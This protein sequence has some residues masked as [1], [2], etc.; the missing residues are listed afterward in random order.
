VDVGRHQS[1]NNGRPPQRLELILHDGR[2]E[3]LRTKARNFCS[4]SLGVRQAEPSS[5]RGKSGRNVSRADAA[6]RARAKEGSDSR[7]TPERSSEWVSVAHGRTSAASESAGH[8][9]RGPGPRGFIEGDRAADRHQH[10]RRQVLPRHAGRVRRI[11]DEPAPR[12][13]A[14]GIAKA[15]AAGVYKGRPASIDATQVRAMKAQG[16]GRIRDREG[17]QDRPRVSLSGR[18]LVDR[19]DAAPG[20]IRS[21]CLSPVPANALVSATRPEWGGTR[22]WPIFRVSNLRRLRFAS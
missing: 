8:R 13:P 10:R 5:A 12:A 20:Q 22:A 9:P 3:R 2:T 4:N 14:Q 16:L 6:K 19:A 1:R 21:F 17:P 15:K 7:W 18:K 11:R